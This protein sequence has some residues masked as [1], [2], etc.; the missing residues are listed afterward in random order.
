MF[1]Y[2]V[3][4]YLMINF[5]P[6]SRFPPEGSDSQR[7]Y[8]MSEYLFGFSYRLLLENVLL[9]K[10]ILI[11]G[12]AYSALLCRIAL[13]TRR[14]GAECIPLL[15]RYV[16]SSLLALLGTHQVVTNL[17]SIAWRLNQC[18]YLE[19]LRKIEFGMDFVELNMTSGFGY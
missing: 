4:F 16:M 9:M 12:T 14:S 7:W 10:V 18:F 13:A 8:G 1:S 3:G 6:H 19:L 17:T 15:N 5:K 11:L 2:L